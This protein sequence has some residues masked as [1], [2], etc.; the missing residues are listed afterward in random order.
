MRKK[1]LSRKL[2]LKKTT[3]SDL[4]REALSRVKGGELQTHE[5]VCTV[6]K[7]CPSIDIACNKSQLGDTVCHNLANPSAVSGSIDNVVC[8]MFIGCGSSA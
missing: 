2:S 6:D 3:V 7:Q 5:T 1:K 4:G 8:T